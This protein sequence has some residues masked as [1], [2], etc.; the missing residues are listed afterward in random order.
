[1]EKGEAWGTDGLGLEAL[2]EDAVQEGLDGGD[3][4]DQQ[5]LGDWN[6]KGLGGLFVKGWLECGGWMSIKGSQ[7]DK[8][9]TYHLWNGEGR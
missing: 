6:V 7:T 4:L 1:M 2:D 8:K 9:S 5:G 3:V